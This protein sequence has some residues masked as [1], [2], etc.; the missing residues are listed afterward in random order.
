[1]QHYRFAVA[2]DGTRY[3]FEVHDAVEPDPPIDDSIHGKLDRIL[4]YNTHHETRWRRF[5]AVRI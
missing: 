5:A 3:R 1:M 4:A 2:E